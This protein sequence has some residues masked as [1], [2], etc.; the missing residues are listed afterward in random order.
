MYDDG[1]F[2]VLLVAIVVLFGVFIILI[3]DDSN[4]PQAKQSDIQAACARHQGV[5][6][7]IDTS[8]KPING[9]VTV[10]CKDGKVVQAK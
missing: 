7:I 2:A 4:G 1:S 5:R 3:S 9:I 6:Q 10:V 8:D